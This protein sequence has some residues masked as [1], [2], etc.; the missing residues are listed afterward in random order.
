MSFIYGTPTSGKTEIWLEVM[1]NLSEIHGWKHAV[2]LPESGG[3]SEIIAELISKAAHKPFYK[4]YQN[5]MSESEM[6]RYLDFIGEHFYIIDP[7]DNSLT[8]DEFYVQ[9]DEIE[10]YYDVKINTTCTDPWNELKHEYG[11]DGRQDLYIENKLGSI[12]R[13]ARKK[14]RHNAVI[15]H[16][17]AQVPVKGTDVN[18]KDIF[19]LPPPTP[20]NISGGLAWYRKAQMMLAIWRPPLNMIDPEQGKPYESNECHIIIQK[21]KPKGTGKKGTVKLYYD[22]NQNRY[23][24]RLGTQSR[25]AGAKGKGKADEAFVF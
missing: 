3:K 25:Y 20:H 24:E 4:D 15:T 16:C 14:N 22:V 7:E 18:G 13:N 12:S 17:N 11:V 2:F 10:K 8:L 6:Y 1:I 21:F 5:H 19:Y 23:Y 9:V